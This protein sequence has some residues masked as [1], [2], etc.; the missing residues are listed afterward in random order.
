M[1][2]TKVLRW[3]RIVLPQ[4]EDKKK[5][6][7]WDRVV[8]IRVDEEE[9]SKMFAI[10]KAS[11]AAGAAGDRGDPQGDGGEKSSKPVRVL[12]EKRF[13]A[14]SILATQLPQGQALVDIITRLD[15]TSVV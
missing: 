1:T 15:R 10:K 3:G 4:D 11:K 12:P 6:S 13:N 2:K 9:V 14:I 8:E 7:V 5:P